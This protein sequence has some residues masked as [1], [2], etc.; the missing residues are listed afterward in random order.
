MNRPINSEPRRL[1]Q[2][3]GVYYFA[4]SA[5]NVMDAVARKI[6]HLNLQ[7][8]SPEDRNSFVIALK[9]LKQT[10]Q[11]KLDTPSQQNS[12]LVWK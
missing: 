5:F 7:A 2:D 3:R 12:N 10:V 4:Q 8:L 6:D 1:P 9:N 11:N